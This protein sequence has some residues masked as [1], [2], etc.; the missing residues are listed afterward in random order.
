MVFNHKIQ[1]GII[2]SGP[3]FGPDPTA[4]DTDVAQMRAT[5]DQREDLIQKL[6]IYL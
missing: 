3:H 5:A 2:P 1:K 4:A 6:A